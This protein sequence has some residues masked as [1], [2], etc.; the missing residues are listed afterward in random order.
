MLVEDDQAQAH[1]V[2]LAVNRH[3]PSY[4][5]THMCDGKQALA[6]LRNKDDHGYA[7]SPNLILLDIK[8]PVMDG[9]EFLSIVKSDPTL[10]HLPVAHVCL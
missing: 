1:L 8:M 9:H 10:Y 5:L 7:P 2:R 6:Y 4:T 3:N